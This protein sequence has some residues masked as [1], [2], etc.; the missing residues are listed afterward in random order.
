M[1]IPAIAYKL[2]LFYGKPGLDRK[3]QSAETSMESS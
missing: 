1:I 2:F 3:L